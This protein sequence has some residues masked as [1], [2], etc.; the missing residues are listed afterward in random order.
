MDGRILE[1]VIGG[2]F[3]APLWNEIN[4][5]EIRKGRP[6]I[7]IKEAI[8]ILPYSL[9]AM[10]SVLVLLSCLW[11]INFDLSMVLGVSSVDLQSKKP[12]KETLGYFLTERIWHTLILA[13]V[14]VCVLTVCVLRLWSEGRKRRKL[15]QSQK[16]AT[17]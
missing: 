4:L 8:K 1:F 11:Q 5:W 10:I 13:L 2:L 16:N 3:L 9:G 15:I 17:V 14:S 12:F 6:P 7:E